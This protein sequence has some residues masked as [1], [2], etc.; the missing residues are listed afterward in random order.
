M[1]FFVSCLETWVGAR[2]GVQQL[3]MCGSTVSVSLN[4]AAEWRSQFR[5]CD[6]GRPRL[7]DQDGCHIRG[8][9]HE[10]TAM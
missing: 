4:K 3:N 8:D 2:V 5:R 6:A 10:A 7:Q 1:P 9:N